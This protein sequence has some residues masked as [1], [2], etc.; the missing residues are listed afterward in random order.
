[1]MVVMSLRFSASI[2]GRLDSGYEFRRRT[3]TRDHHVRTRNAVRGPDTRSKKG[4]GS[5]LA[6]GSVRIAPWWLAN[7]IAPALPID[8]AGCSALGYDRVA[9]M[10]GLVPWRALLSLAV[11]VLAGG[12]GAS[13][14][15]NPHLNT[16]SALGPA[17]ERAAA[18]FSRQVLR[19]DEVWMAR[20]GGWLLGGEFEDWSRALFVESRVLSGSQFRLVDLSLTPIP[21]LSPPLAVPESGPVRSQVHHISRKEMRN[22]HEIMALSTACRKLSSPQRE[23]LHSLLDEPGRG[24][25]VTHQLWGLITAH[26]EGCLESEGIEHRRAPL[27]TAV[28]RELLA[29]PGFDDLTAE[30]MAMLSYGGLSHWI[31]QDVIERALTTQDE[32][33]PWIRHQVDIGPH[34]SS[35]VMHMSTLAFYG[36]AAIH[37]AESE[38]GA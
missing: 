37:V 26:H 30:R 29:D 19:G 22:I 13:P 31:P 12:C 15:S 9:P 11:G 7:A 2:D 28:Y 18:Y 34:A 38:D 27:A 21:P 25:V 14:S 20:Q 32:S 16:S 23:K 3:S 35:T 6:P 4:G 1:M 8:R 17:L 36:L 10:H 24:Y 5:V 33:G